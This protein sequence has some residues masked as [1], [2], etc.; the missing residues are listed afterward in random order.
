MCFEYEGGLRAFVDYL[1]TNKLTIN[2]A[3]HFS[4]FRDDGGW[5]RNRITV[6]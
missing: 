4:K 3:V 1:N 6:E 5:G 2:K